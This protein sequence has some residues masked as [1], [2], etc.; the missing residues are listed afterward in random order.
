[1]ALCDQMLKFHWSVALHSQVQ[2]N[3]THSGLSAFL[4]RKWIS[5]GYEPATSLVRHPILL[6]LRLQNLYGTLTTI[7][8]RQPAFTTVC[9][10]F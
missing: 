1:M 2:G 3:Q 8:E 5:A 6:T 10:L 7:A 4:V 9:Q